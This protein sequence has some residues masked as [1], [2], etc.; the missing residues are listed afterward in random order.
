MPEGNWYCNECLSKRGKT[1]KY[2]V[3]IFSKLL[4]QSEIRNPRKF[5]LPRKLRESTFENVSTGPCGEYQDSSVSKNTRPIK[6]GKLEELDP[7]NIYDKNGKPL[8]CYRCGLTGLNKEITKCGYCDLSWHLDCLNPPL[9][10]VKTLGTKW[11]CP[12][13][14]LDLIPTKKRR[15]KRQNYVDVSMSRGFKNNG[16]VEI[17]PESEEEVDNNEEDES[18]LTTPAYMNTYYK[19]GKIHA[20]MSEK[21]EKI[22]TMNNITYRIPEKGVILDFI[23]SSKIKKLGDPFITMASETDAIESMLDLKSKP[24]VHSTTSFKELLS[25]V[26]SELSK[27]ANGYEDLTDN[28]I[29]DLKYLKKLIDIKGRDNLLRFLQS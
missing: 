4:N 12:N 1:K 17:A 29:E 28:E 14:V 11:K 15:Y 13:H 27:S 23:D 5:Q 6:L 9:P 26:N 3:G 22:I 19:D 25:V 7:L 8:I 2:T 16:D 21:M 24:V 20:P 10:S 18:N